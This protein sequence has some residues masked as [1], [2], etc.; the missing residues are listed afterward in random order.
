MLNLI[1]IPQKYTEVDTALRPRRA[2][3]ATAEGAW[4]RDAAL[5]AE[6]LGQLFDLSPA[7]G[8]D[9]GICLAHDAALPADAYVLD[10]T[11]D[12]IVLRASDREGLLYAFASLLQLLSRKDDVLQLP[13]L[14]IEDAPAKPYRGFMLDAVSKPQTLAQLF[15]YVDLCFFYKV[16]YL[17]LHFADGAAYRYPSSRFEKLPSKIHFTKEDIEALRR[18]AD[19]RGIKLIPE[20]ECPGH[21]TILNRACPEHFSCDLDGEG[22]VLYNELGGV[23]DPQSLICAGSERSFDAICRLIDE[24]LELFPDSKYLHIGGDEAPHKGWAHCKTCRAYM[25]AHGLKNT[26]EL[27]SEYVGRVAAYVLSKGR[28]PIAWEGFS[29]E[30]SH[31]VPKETVI[32]AWESHYQ[33]A[34]DLLKNGFQIINAS[35]QPTYFVPSLTHRW[36][37]R[38][39]LHWDPHV[40]EHWWEHSQ[41]RDVPIRIEPTDDLLGASLCSWGLS[42]ELLISRLMENLPAFSQSVWSPAQKPDFAT[43]QNVY[44]AVTSVASDLILDKECE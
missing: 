13:S 34:P 20:I 6:Q 40:W 27:Y 12:A 17:H 39:L 2:T 4:E 10:S 38:E 37:A 24:V 15:K 9:A 21:A 16:N 3:V 43:Y 26:K 29:S 33:I 7:D 14:L 19:A 1:P 36:G 8:E 30:S 18:Y 41:A 44:K 32:I 35:W 5:L 31:F 22:E 11:D 23:I 42:F 28:I 25:E